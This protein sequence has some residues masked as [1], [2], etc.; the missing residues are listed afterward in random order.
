MAKTTALVITTS[1]ACCSTLPASSSTVRAVFLNLSTSKLTFTDVFRTNR[2]DPSISDTSS[3]LDLSPLYGLNQDDQNTVRTFKDGK[4]KNDVFAE[5]RLLGFPPGVSAFLLMFGRFHNYVAEQLKVI[6]QGERFSLKF[7]RRWYADDQETKNAKALKQQD[8]DLFQTARLV[9]CGLYINFVLNDYLRTIVNLNR[10]DTTWTL[11]P[12]YDSSPTNTPGETPAGTGNMISV[13]FNLVYRWHSC[14]SKRDDVW[15]QEFY[16]NLF[17]GKDTA[18]L[19][20]QEFV[21]GVHKWEQSIPEDPA[22]RTFGGFKRQPDGHFSDDDLVSLLTESIEDHAGKKTPP[23]IGSFSN[24]LSPRR[25]WCSKCP[26]YSQ[27]RRSP[28]N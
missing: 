1:A 19:T 6:N 27:A 14:I 26:T 20:M 11:D 5:K 8:E 17:P 3:Y 18:K 16:Q 13:E 23:F 12:R 9:T 7:D 10:V 22:E 25:I 15:T 4:L 28:R 21:A 2:A 24:H